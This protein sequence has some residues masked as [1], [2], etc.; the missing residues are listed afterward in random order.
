MENRIEE[1][2][3][4]GKNF[5]YID[6]SGLAS[7]VDFIE[8]IKVAEPAIAKHP[9]NS[10]YTITNIAS[11]KLDSYSKQIA[12]KYTENN[13]KYVKF[14]V[15]IGFDGIKKMMVRTVMKLSGRT[16]MEFAFTKE[17]AIEFLVQ[18]D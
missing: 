8:V 7:D 1:F 2:T 4:E 10:V 6:F 11:L 12:G 14:G 16:N 15:I 13:K 9:E 3:R 5:V 17:Q 18:H